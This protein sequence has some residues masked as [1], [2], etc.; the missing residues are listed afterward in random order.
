MEH[1]RDKFL[2]SFVDKPL[3]I[4]GEKEVKIVEFFS[5]LNFPMEHFAQM[6]VNK[7]VLGIFE[8]GLCIWEFSMYQVHEECK[9]SQSNVK[10]P[11]PKDNF[12][13]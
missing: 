6:G 12:V 3:A 10:S 8:V 5:L 1:G 4:F 9:F 2:R 11:S 7:I 13:T